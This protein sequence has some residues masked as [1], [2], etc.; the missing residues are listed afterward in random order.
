MRDTSIDILRGIA[1]VTM[2]AANW[3][4]FILTAPHPFW[5]RVYGSFA[6][7]LFIFLAG[8]MVTLTH[9]Q[10]GHDFK[11]FVY[12][13]AYLIVVGALL[14][15]LGIWKIHPF[16]SMEV[17]YLI[18]VSLPLSFCFLR[19]P[20]WVAWFLVG[21]VFWIAPL[22]QKHFGYTVYPTTVSITGQDISGVSF[23][24]PI[25]QHWLIDGWFPVFPWIG[26]AF[27]GA[28]LGGMKEMGYAIS[29][30]LGGIGILFGTLFFYF[31]PNAFQ[32]RGSFSELFYPP[33]YGYIALSLGVIFLLQAMI[34]KGQNFTFPRFFALFGRHALLL[35]ILHLAIA[36]YLFYPFWNTLSISSFLWV[37]GIG[38]GVL[39]SLCIILEELTKKDH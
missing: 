7:P 33:S 37:Y 16:L 2:V 21:S 14:V 4:A 31:M 9:L 25:W 29:G 8:R 19:L 12:R 36:Q 32:L 34:Q 20:R 22:L 17:L 3:A 28:L 39:W 15:D 11:Y 10:K 23:Q 1:I 38:I 30:C 24:S 35:Y 5:L 27:L 6:A 13:G 18:G 26:Y